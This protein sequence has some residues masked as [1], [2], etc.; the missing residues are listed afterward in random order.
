[1]TPRLYLRTCFTF[2]ILCASL[3]LL[4]PFNL[5]VVSPASVV[6]SSSQLTT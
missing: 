5:I 4:V 3:E 6:V 2:V 1:M